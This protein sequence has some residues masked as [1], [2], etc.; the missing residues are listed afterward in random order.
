MNKLILLAACLSLSLSLT[1]G[2]PREEACQFSINLNEAVNDELAVTLIVPNAIRDLS[3]EDVTY[4]LPKMVP[5]TYK[6]YDFGR[7]VQV[8]QAFDKKG[9]RLKVNR[10][11]N[12]TWVIS[13]PSKLYKITY[14]VEDTWDTY[15]Q[16][17]IFEPAGSSIEQK[18]FY[19]IN[20]HA[21]FGYF[22]NQEK[23]DYYISVDRPAEFFGATSLKRQRGDNDTDN[24]KAGNY[25]DL[26]DAPIMYSVPDT[27]RFN[28]GAGTSILV[29]LYD[30]SKRVTAQQISMEL[31]PLLQAQRQYLGG[32]LPVDNYVFQIHVNDKAYPSKSYGA[33]EHCKGAT[34]CLVP[35]EPSKLL[36]SIRDVASHEFFHIVTP[37][38]IH[39]EEI[40]KFNFNEPKM[41]MH[42]WLYEGVVE[43]MSQ[44]VQ[45][46]Y[47]MISAQE[48]FDNMSQKLQYAKFFKNVS[49]VFLSK[50]C[51]SD[52]YKKQYINIYQ[53]GAIAAM[54]LDLILMESSKGQYTLTK[55]LMDLGKEYGP[56]RSFKD[57]VLFEDIDRL[58]GTREARAFLNRCVADTAKFPLA[59]LAK[60]AGVD[61]REKGEKRE[62]SP[63]GGLE[64]GA[65][66]PNESGELYVAR[67]EKLDAFGRDIIKFQKGDILKSWNG[68]ELNEKN[69]LSVILRYTSTAREGKQLEV[70]VQRAGKLVTLKA[71]LVPV[72]VMAENVFDFDEKASEDARV[73]RLAWVNAG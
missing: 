10:P 47:G 52:E 62:L 68:Q 30:R 11:D 58:S 6:V 60:L 27:M 66:Q 34:I 8:F 37:L 14:Y 19:L 25:Y 38:N 3:T 39:S 22:E 26:V 16:N 69:T 1:A 51:L 35:D 44:H 43:Y 56:T 53:K 45:V 31:L 12:N 40:G 67:P 61:F 55:L 73:I 42:L 49:L 46:K 9:T 32:T 63:L 33:L 28:V 7:F 65:L 41:S 23:L 29:A 15:Q 64:N 72:N 54:C 70:G 71:T 24:F 21:F 59:S 13:E 5:G 20:N 36:R 48:F 17:T 18:Q 57:E 50:N 2:N 4:R